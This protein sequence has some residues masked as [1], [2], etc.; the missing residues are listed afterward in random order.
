MAQLIITI[1]TFL[2]VACSSLQGPN[3]EHLI[4][5]TVILPNEIYHTHTFKNNTIIHYL[6]SSICIPCNFDLINI[7][8]RYTNEL[9]SLNVDL[10]IL[11]NIKYDTTLLEIARKNRISCPIYFTSGDSYKTNNKLPDSYEYQTIMIDSSMQ[12]EW[13]GLPVI[14]KLT[15]NKFIKHKKQTKHEK[16]I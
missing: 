15:W 1:L 16:N 9:D 8:N 14:N 5:Q 13:V 3:T 7:W 11:C 4:G 2:F 10:I 12:I 6:D